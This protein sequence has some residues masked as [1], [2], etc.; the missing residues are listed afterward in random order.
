MVKTSA[1]PLTEYMII[2]I[3]PRSTT[4]GAGVLIHPLP[5]KGVLCNLTISNDFYWGACT[6]I[7]IFMLSEMS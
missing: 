2:T 1:V 7:I 4:K 5:K 6:C 3:Q